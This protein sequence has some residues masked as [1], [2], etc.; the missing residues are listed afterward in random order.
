MVYKMFKSLSQGLGFCKSSQNAALGY[1]QRLRLVS[2]QNKHSYS[3]CY[4]L[5][6]TFPKVTLY[7][8]YIYGCTCFTTPSI[9]G[10]FHD[11]IYNYLLFPCVS[12]AY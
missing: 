1:I 9:I 6:D 2:Q 12:P 10:Y 11:Y 8:C 3:S 5:P 7:L 4:L